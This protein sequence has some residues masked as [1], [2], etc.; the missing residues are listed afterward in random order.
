MFII[1]WSILVLLLLAVVVNALQTRRSSY[2]PLTEQQRRDR[3]ELINRYPP[4]DYRWH[5]RSSNRPWRD[6]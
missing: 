3:L 1:L 6:L 5:L 2:R 4:G